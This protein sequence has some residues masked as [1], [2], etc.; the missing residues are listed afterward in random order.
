MSTWQMRV[1][2]A[3]DERYDYGARVMKTHELPAGIGRIAYS[4]ADD[5]ILYSHRNL[6]D[7]A[8][9][10]Y[11][12]TG[13]TGQDLRE[14]V[15]FHRGVRDTMLTHQHG[16]N[17]LIQ[18]YQQLLLNP[19]QSVCDIVW[20]LWEEGNHPVSTNAVMEIIE[21]VDIVSSRQVMEKLR[22]EHPGVPWG[23]DQHSIFDPDTHIYMNHVSLYGGED[24]RWRERLHR[25]DL[26]WVE[27][28][29]DVD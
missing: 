5:R 7:F 24:D 23:N 17:L 16:A 8:A 27:A 6:R 25:D 1:V 3:L 14:F 29:E 19:M 9:S 15:E 12:S 13:R 26:G 20:L 28:L 11:E 4:S 21:E 10:V 18:P 2:K 22:Q